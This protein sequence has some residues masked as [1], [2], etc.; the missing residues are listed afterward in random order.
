MPPPLVFQSLRTCQA[1]IVTYLI[2]P[3]SMEYPV[4][5]SGACIHSAQA[6]VKLLIFFAYQIVRYLRLRPVLPRIV[7]SRLKVIYYATSQR[8]K[9][10]DVAF[11]GPSTSTVPAPGITV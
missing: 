11:A 3:H 5:N 7:K 2:D 1:I 9:S 10:G 4:Q 6:P 8:S